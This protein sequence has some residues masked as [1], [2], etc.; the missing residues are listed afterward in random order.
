MSSIANVRSLPNSVTRDASAPGVKVQL[1]KLKKEQAACVNCASAKT[2]AG[3]RNIQRLNTQIQQLESRL[4]I[5]RTGRDEAVMT[6]ASSTASLSLIDT[7][8]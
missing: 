7:Y 5:Q 6:P 3:Q 8:A 1:E 4:A 2:D